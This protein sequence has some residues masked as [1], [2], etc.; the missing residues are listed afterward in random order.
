MGDTLII[1][2]GDE[3]LTSAEMTLDGSVLVACTITGVKIFRLRRK[4]DDGLKVSKMEVPQSVAGTGAKIAKFSPDGKWLLLVR[5]S[6]EV[7]MYRVVKTESSRTGLSFRPKAVHLK[8]LSREPT[9][10]KIQCGS[11]GRYERSVSRVAFSANSKIITTGDLCG[12]LD[13]W[14]LEGHE[15]LTQ[16][17]DQ[18]DNAS[19]SSASS[20]DETADEADQS[21][22]ILGQRWIRNPAASLLPQLPAAPLILS[23]RPSRSHSDSHMP[24][25]NMI[26]HPTRQPPHPHSLHVAPGEDRLF[27][28]T[29]DHQMYEFNILS[30]KL[31]NWSRRNPTASL[32][33]KFRKII[34]RVKGSVWDTNQ[35][36]ERI[37]VYGSSWLWMFDL[38]KDFPMEAEAGNVTT[39]EDAAVEV[40]G[41][42]SSQ[43][44][45]RRIDTNVEEEVRQSTGAGG[46]AL[47]SELSIG[48]GRKFWK[49]KGPDLTQSHWVST[50]GEQTLSLDRDDNHAVNESALIRLR[51]DSGQRSQTAGNITGV[52]KIDGCE[53][54]EINDELRIDESNSYNG[55]PYWGTHKYRDILGI[56]PLGSRNREGENGD[57]EL[58]G[59][60][61]VALVERPI[62]DVELPPKYYGNQE[63]DK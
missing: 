21:G 33:L 22:V 53:S 24:N 19:I 5:S 41:T 13:S 45:R 7:E 29:S 58:P 4:A 61:E 46:R 62:W 8:R 59:G 49:A 14:V 60:V 20:D 30:G 50:D 55:L 47:D 48:I 23:F 9:K 63:W 31:S 39:S 43:R 2:Q 54:K 6:G 36:K 52:V 37:W 26:P 42:K 28:L 56:V 10:R 11:L 1:P 38:S 40:N 18:A 27:A 32:P 16:E 35:A 44:K 25:G 51:R 12:Y 17:D 3:A 57:D 15:D 34:E